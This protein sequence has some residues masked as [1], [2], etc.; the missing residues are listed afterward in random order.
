MGGTFDPLH[1]GHL[2]AAEE[3]R[4]A[5]GLARVL[6]IPCGQPYHK[7]AEPLASREDR[8]RMTVLGTADN[9]EFMP[10]RIEIDRPGPSY[11]IDTVRALRRDNPQADYYVILGA[12][13]VNLVL[14]WKDHEALFDECQF[15]VVSREGTDAGD[16]K[17]QVPQAFLERCHWLDMPALDISSTMIRRR[18]SQRRPIRY[19][20]PRPV[21]QYIEQ[22]GLYR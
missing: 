1:L 4:V 5:L 2:A 13:A 7:Q 11:T 15:A 18:V 8:Y 3:A 10:S 20:V 22:R 9:A 17:V 21:E 6:F 19:L 14:T 12:D 16:I